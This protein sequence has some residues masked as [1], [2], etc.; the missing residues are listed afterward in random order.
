M[1]RK[2]KLLPLLILSLSLSLSACMGL[3]PLE[4]EPISGDFGPQLS[5]QEQQSETFEM[6]WKDVQENYIYF[7]TAE[8]D[9]DAL[10]AGYLQRIKSG[11]TPEEFGALID[12]LA[13]ELPEAVSG[14]NPGPSASMP[15]L[16]IPPPMKGSA[17]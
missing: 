9:W 5:L 14:I 8:V 11:L 2:T 15:M 13:A 16:R 4:E 7:E 12:D 10:H 3:I 1:K 6:L 17:L